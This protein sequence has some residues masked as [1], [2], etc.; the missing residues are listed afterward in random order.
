MVMVVGMAMGMQLANHQFQ[1]ERENLVS[2]QQLD[3]RK[4][5]TDIANRELIIN[6][7]QQ[8]NGRL[9]DA[10]VS[11]ASESAAVELEEIKTNQGLITQ[12]NA[13]ISEYKKS[14]VNVTQVEKD[15]SGAT[16]L[17]VTGKSVDLRTLIT[18]LDG[19]LEKNLATKKEEDKKKAAAA[20]SVPVTNSPA[21]GYSRIT[22]TT[23]GGN[24]VTDVIKA[25]LGSTSVITVTGNDGNCDNNCNVKPLADYIAEESGYAGINGTYFCPPDYSG[26]SG[27]VNAYDFP[28]YSTRYGKWI[29]ADKLFWNDRGMAAFSGLSPRFCANASGCDNGAISAGIVNYP[30]LVSGGNVVVNTGGLP[31]SLT[32]TKGLRGGIGVKGS[33]IYLLVVRG[34]TVAD[35]AEV[36]KALGIEHGLNLDGGGSS[37]LYYGGYKVGPG[38]LLPNAI[39]LK[40]R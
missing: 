36:M 23:S 37:A 11:V 4:L 14:G 2:V 30:T 19:N 15:M 8:E 34:A 29:N 17:L 25:D 13:K 1:S 28:V 40:S 10:Y 33:E 38:R 27:K 9:L 7:L 6:T 32:Q 20:A 21:G 16:D 35:E 12:L 31:A 18:K 39:V 5:Q 22:V 3:E 24:F 26:C